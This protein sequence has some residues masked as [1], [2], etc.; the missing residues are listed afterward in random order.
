MRPGGSEAVD[1]V[2]AI[3]LGAV[4]AVAVTPVAGLGWAYLASFVA[5]V[6]VGSWR[7]ILSLVRRKLR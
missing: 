3:V 5:G 1:W 4:V 6:L 7:E 2:L